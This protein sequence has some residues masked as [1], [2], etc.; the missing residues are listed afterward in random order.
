VF[1]KGVIAKEG[2]SQDN[3][4]Y[5]LQSLALVKFLVDDEDISKIEIK[6][7]NDYIPNYLKSKG[8]MNGK[9]ISFDKWVDDLTDRVVM[10]C[11]HEYPEQKIVLKPNKGR[12][13]PSENQFGGIMS[14]Y[15][16]IMNPVTNDLV[17]EGN[18]EDMGVWMNS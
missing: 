18:G 4:I 2:M 12:A 6:F 1:Q 10:R 9:T 13:R 7:R 17:A 3:I 8:I 14:S 11:R 5:L 16:Y 15:W